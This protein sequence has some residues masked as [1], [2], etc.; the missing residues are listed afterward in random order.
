MPYSITLLIL[1]AIAL[2]ALIDVG[3]GQVLPDHLVQQGAPVRIGLREFATR[4]PKWPNAIGF[5]VLEL[6]GVDQAAGVVRLCNVGILD[7]MPVLDIK[8]YVPAFD[9]WD[10]ERIGWL[11]D[12]VGGAETC[13]A[14]DRFR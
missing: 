8:P 10:A 2:L 7:G 1:A 12:K 11:A 9:V 13:K 6:S 14:D 3:L 5:S 4:S